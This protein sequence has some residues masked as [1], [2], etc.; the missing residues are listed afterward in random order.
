MSIHSFILNGQDIIGAALELHGATTAIAL[1]RSWSLQFHQLPFPVQTLGHAK[2]HDAIVIFKNW[3]NWSEPGMPT[4]NAKD[5][6]QG[7][8]FFIRLTHRVG[9]LFLQS[10][11]GTNSSHDSVTHIHE[12]AAR[13][14]KGSDGQQGHDAH[15]MQDH[16]MKGTIF[17]RTKK[18][19]PTKER[20]SIA[21][22]HPRVD[23]K[24]NKMLEIAGT[25]TIV[26]P[27]TVMIHS[28]NTAIANSA[29][30]GTWRFECLA[31]STHAV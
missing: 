16:G 5:I 20:Q 23:Q 10:I 28:G 8:G 9:G 11:N 21:G 26:H 7:N 4:G 2:T 3:V 22:T 30:M 24:Q 12:H 6:L 25:D 19:I 29:M 13:K 1:I 31:L 18:V 14:Q 17:I 27:R 15:Q